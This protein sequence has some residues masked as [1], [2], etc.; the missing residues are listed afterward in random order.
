MARKS[1][2][3]LMSGRPGEGHE[4]RVGAAGADPLGERE[5]VLR[6][7]RGLVLDEVRLVDDHPAEAVLAEPADVPVE[8]LVV[9]DDDVGEAV[10]GVAVAVDDGRRAARGPQLGLVGPVR[11]DDVGDDDEQREGAGGVGGEERLRRLAQ[12]RLVGEEERAVALGGGRDDL[13]LVVH[14]L[15]VADA[16]DDVARARAAACRWRRRRTRRPGTGG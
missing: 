10:G 14:Q 13:G 3:S 7:L 5:D 1:S 6:A 8:D 16:V 15:E 11:L 4:Q 9:D 12:A 2:M